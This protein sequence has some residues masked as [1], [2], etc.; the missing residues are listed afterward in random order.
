VPEVVQRLEEKVRPVPG[1]EIQMCKTEF[2]VGE[3]KLYLTAEG[4]PDWQQPSK[5]YAQ[6]DEHPVVNVSWTEATEL[7]KWLSATT[8]R[9]WRLPTNE[10]WQ[11]AVGTSTYP[12]GDYFPPHS[13]DGNYSITLDGKFDPL[14]VGGDGIYKTAPL[15][16]FRP[17]SLGF[18]DLGGNVT[19]VMYELNEKGQ[20][21]GRGGSWFDH[22]FTRSAAA[23][24]RTLR[25][26]DMAWGFR[27]VCK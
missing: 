27:L 24:A 20:A 15:A 23:V 9:E 6:T 18:Y 4:L 2:R 17:N 1:T 25:R 12:W 16:S 21:V 26:G 7:C 11:A 14:R 13:E 3:W 10:E 19:E 8:G 5:D 22:G